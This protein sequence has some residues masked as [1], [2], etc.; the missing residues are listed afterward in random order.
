MDCL[1]LDTTKMYSLFLGVLPDELYDGKPIVA[2]LENMPCV[3]VPGK[4]A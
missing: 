3:I 1:A 2:A 4:D